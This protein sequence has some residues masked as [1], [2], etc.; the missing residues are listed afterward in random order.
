MSAKMACHF[1]AS[2]RD[3][4][5]NDWL[6]QVPETSELGVWMRRLAAGVLDGPDDPMFQRSRSC[7][8]IDFQGRPPLK[9]VPV[10]DTARSTTTGR[11]TPFNWCH[12]LVFFSAM[13]MD[14]RTA[15][16]KRL[17]PYSN[18]VVRCVRHS[19]VYGRQ[20]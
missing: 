15:E 4:K 2:A 6:V 18:L 10:L 11:T 16:G 3:I 20:Q 5:H 7:L 14:L 13:P 19:A 17:I 12:D 1:T 9:Y 8:T